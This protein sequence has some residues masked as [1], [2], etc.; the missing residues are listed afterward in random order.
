MGT[1]GSLAA[2]TGSVVPGWAVCVDVGAAG[3]LMPELRTWLA[4]GP[5]ACLPRVPPEQLPRLHRV[6]KCSM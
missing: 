2:G 4:W 6:P 1:V 3:R 5:A